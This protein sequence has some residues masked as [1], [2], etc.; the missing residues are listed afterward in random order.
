MDSEDFV[1]CIS[2][3]FEDNQMIFIPKLLKKFPLINGRVHKIKNTCDYIYNRLVKRIR[4]RKKEVEKIVNTSNYESSQLKNDLLTLMVIANTPYE[5][6]PQ[7]NVDSSLLRPMTDDEIR[8][9][10]FDAFAA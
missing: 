1:E 6:S 5:T 2:N 4:Q 7:K 10:M 3:F 8:G 9:I